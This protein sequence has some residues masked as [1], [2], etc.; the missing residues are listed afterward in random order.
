MLQLPLSSGGKPS[1]TGEWPWQAALHDV[2]KGDVV[3]GGALVR[4]EWVLTAAH[5]VA[6]DGTERPRNRNGIS[7]YLG[8]HNRSNSMDDEYVQKRQVRFA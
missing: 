1:Y 2:K 3:C 4:E 5:C 8:K 6:I 7:V